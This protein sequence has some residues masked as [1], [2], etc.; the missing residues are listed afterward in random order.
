MNK[1][2]YTPYCHTPILQIPYSISHT[3]AIFPSWVT[4]LPSSTYDHI[5]YTH[6]H[7][8]T[9]THTQT[10]TH[11]HTHTHT[12]TYP[13]PH[14]TY[15]IPHTLVLAAFFPSWVTILP[16]SSDEYEHSRCSSTLVTMA[17]VLQCASQSQVTQPN[18]I[19]I[20]SAV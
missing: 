10:H 1:N 4:R 7:T 17:T 6:T 14:T 11:T 2:L 19:T 18:N 3:P 9:H 12:L 8:H 16:S 15:P 13:I 5:S 20:H